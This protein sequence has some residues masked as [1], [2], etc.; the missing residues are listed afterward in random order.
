M[1]EEAARCEVSRAIIV[2]DVRT[3]NVSSPFPSG[4]LQAIANHRLDLGVVGCLFVVF[5]M[6]DE[7]SGV[8]LL[9]AYRITE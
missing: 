7:E 4:R 3:L 1:L 2:L 6:P 8:F 9:S 5:E